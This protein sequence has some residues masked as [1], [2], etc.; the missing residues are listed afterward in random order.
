MTCSQ[1]GQ[2][3]EGGGEMGVKQRGRISEE[4]MRR[5]GKEKEVA[6]ETKT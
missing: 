4:K 1:V 3:A 6:M 2:E 5:E